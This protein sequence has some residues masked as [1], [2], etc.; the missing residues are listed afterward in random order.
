MLEYEFQEA[1]CRVVNKPFGPGGRAI[2]VIE[3]S[4][5]LPEL[6]KRMDGYMVRVRKEDVLKDLPAIRWDVVPVQPTQRFVGAAVVPACRD[7]ATTKFSDIW[8]AGVITSCAFRRMIGIAKAPAAIEY[9][10]DFLTNLHS[11]RPENSRF[12][13]PQGCHRQS[14]RQGSATPSQPSLS[15][16]TNPA[17]GNE[18][19][20]CFLPTTIAGF[21]LA[22][23]KPPGPP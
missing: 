22:I 4:K 6:R 11:S 7:D 23:S 8:R 9:L 12:R 5:N 21:S 19:S 1:F 14:R 10:D 20:T 18:T 16:E 17:V 13:A 3:G 15:G 2:R